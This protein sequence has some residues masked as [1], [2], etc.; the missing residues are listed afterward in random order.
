[1]NDVGEVFGSGAVRFSHFKNSVVGYH[2][3]MQT[4]PDVDV[5][6]LMRTAAEQERARKKRAAVTKP[7][8]GWRSVVGLLGDSPFEREAWAVG[9]AWRKGQKEP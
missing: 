4:K 2:R 6:P 1:M 8:L 3:P 5:G 9:E 7:K